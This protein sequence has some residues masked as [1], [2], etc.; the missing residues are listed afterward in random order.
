LEQPDVPAS[1]KYSEE[2]RNCPRYYML[3]L[4]KKRIFRALIAFFPTDVP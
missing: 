2:K 1:K 3:K 4:Y